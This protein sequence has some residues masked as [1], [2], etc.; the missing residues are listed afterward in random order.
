M[1]EAGS[2]DDLRVVAV[3]RRGP[4]RISVQ[5]QR[6]QAVPAPVV[7]KPQQRVRAVVQQVEH[8]QLHRDVL[9][10]LCGRPPD[11]HPG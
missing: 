5:A 7:G 11:V 2:Q 4:D 10:Q 9:D 1:L 6:L 3:P 8:V